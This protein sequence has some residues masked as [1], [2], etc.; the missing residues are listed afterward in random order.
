M[1]QPDDPEDPSSSKFLPSITTYKDS[2]DLF[3]S[4][5]FR[6][7]VIAKD[8]RLD[9]VT[10][11]PMLD[12]A[13]Y[14]DVRMDTWPVTSQKQGFAPTPSRFSPS[15][16]V[17]LNLFFLLHPQSSQVSS[18]GPRSVATDLS[19]CLPALSLASLETCL[20]GFPQL[21]PNQAPRYPELRTRVRAACCHS[22]S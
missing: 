12:W 15:A 14:Q 13:A 17:F 21:W 19:L 9:S 1:Y 2:L 10:K 5:K 16:W 6:V 4:I 3:I 22:F 8:P 20:T 18:W 7:E 11:D